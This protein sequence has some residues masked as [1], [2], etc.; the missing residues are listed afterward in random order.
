LLGGGQLLVSSGV[1]LAHR[2]NIPEF[3]IG[4]TVLTFGTTT[5]ELTVSIVGGIQQGIVAEASNL[6]VAQIVGSVVSNLGLILGLSGLFG[7]L[8]IDK[9]HLFFQAFFMIGSVSLLAFFSRNG[10]ISQGESV[11]L[12]LAAA[13]YFI[14]LAQ[15]MRHHDVKP[16]K[17]VISLPTAIAQLVVGILVLVV[18]SELVLTNGIALAEMTNLS[19]TFIGLFVI[20][21][22]TSSP[23]LVVAITAAFRKNRALSIGNIIGSNI[24]NVL[25]ALPAGAIFSGFAVGRGLQTFDIPFA[26]LMSVVVILF[27]FTRAQ[28]QR[29]EALLV[30]GLY[31]AYLGFKL[32][33]L[34]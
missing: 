2:F 10:F 18:G 14:F 9:K 12:L 21:V 30:V 4:L 3:M 25:V 20:G 31:F 24:F 7:A 1:S 28:L 22:G 26:I 34:F 32:F 15:I 11:I 33:A 29:K 5:P 13:V 17:V 8:V 6:L 16:Q 19:Q 23:E 27:F